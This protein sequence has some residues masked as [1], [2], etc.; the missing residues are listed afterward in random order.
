VTSG[1][2]SHIESNEGRRAQAE[3]LHN[4]RTS[5][6]L[7]AKYC[8]PD[9]SRVGFLVRPSRSRLGSSP[10][11]FTAGG[12]SDTAP[13]QPDPPKK[14]AIRCRNYTCH[15]SKPHYQV[16]ELYI[17]CSPYCSAMRQLYLCYPLTD[18]PKPLLYLALSE[19]PSGSFRTDISAMARSIEKAAWSRRSM[20]E[21]TNRPRLRILSFSSPRWRPPKSNEPITAMSSRILLWAPRTSQI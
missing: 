16:S 12:W 1:A 2:H 5:E 8:V 15:A 14:D 17:R 7:P 3:Y 18:L 9:F 13:P 20:A 21:S 6:Q 4:S 10:V 19:I 11:G